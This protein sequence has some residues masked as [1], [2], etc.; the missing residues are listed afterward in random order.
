MWCL[1]F[2]LELVVD[3]FFFDYWFIVFV[4]IGRLCIMV[5]ILLIFVWIFCMD[6]FWCLCVMNGAI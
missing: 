4:F 2:L 3:F 5:L 1:K 6:S